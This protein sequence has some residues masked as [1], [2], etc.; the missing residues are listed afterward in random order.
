MLWPPISAK[1]CHPLANYT[2]RVFP[3]TG[4]RLP[5]LPCAQASTL[6]SGRNEKMSMK[7]VR[8]PKA[9]LLNGPGVST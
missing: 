9:A 6:R 3:E 1:L 4:V 8:N 2:I 5:D 7:R